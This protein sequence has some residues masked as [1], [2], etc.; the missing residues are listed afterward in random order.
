MS[1][2]GVNAG[3]N[4]DFGPGV[5]ALIGARF[6]EHVWDG[7]FPYTAG[8]MVPTGGTL[9]L[10]RYV[11]GGAQVT[12]HH[13]TKH[14]QLLLCTA[15]DC[16]VLLDHQHGSYLDISVAVKDDVVAADK[17]VTNIAELVPPTIV[18]S[19]SVQLWLWLMTQTG[20]ESKS[21]T[22]KASTWADVS[23]HYPTKV[24]DRLAHIMKADRPEGSGKIILWHGAPGTGKTSAI[25]TLMREWKP[26]CKFHYISDPEDLFRHPAYLLTVATSEKNDFRL[27]IAEDADNLLRPSARNDPGSGLGRLLNFSDGILGQGCN[28]IFLLT[29]NI[30]LDKLHPAV[31]R[32]GR[33]FAQVEF[34][35]F[36]PREVSDWCLSENVPV[37]SGEKTLAELTEHARKNKQIATGLSDSPDGHGMYL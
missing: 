26:W 36:S 2:L 31:T 33:C 14:S 11:P 3:F 23:R 21:K 15:D 4:L 20:S 12:R 7:G 19:D 18:D 13:T 30:E 28:T 22:I 27:V 8:R 10:A 29:T 25:R 5:K 9:D 24:T 16:I 6:S 34:T 37:L 35:K 17:I 1:D 32:P